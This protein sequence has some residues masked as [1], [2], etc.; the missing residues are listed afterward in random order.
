MSLLVITDE[1]NNMTD[2]QLEDK[3]INLKGKQYVQVVDRITYFNDNY[4]DGS[5]RT[6]LVSQPGS[7]HYVV[8]AKVIPDASKPERYFSG[9]SQAVLGE[10]GANKDAA[11]ENAETSAVGRALGM[12]GIGVIDS[13]ASADEMNKA[14]VGY[15]NT[16]KSAQNDKNDQ[17]C[18][19][20]KCSM[21]L[22]KNG[23]PYHLDRSRAEGDQFCNGM[24]F[25][26]EHTKHREKIKAQV[27]NEPDP[28]S[29]E[30]ASD[31]P[32]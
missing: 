25:P 16:S 32:F 31:L 28:T 10:E 20:H 26:S 21:K 2:K 8:H 5:I 14:N 6:K 7:T 9:L 27:N 17:W 13:V 24:G 15:S 22:N 23:K 4:P 19:Y 3:A 11:L 12:M 1:E 29:D 30:V 18:D